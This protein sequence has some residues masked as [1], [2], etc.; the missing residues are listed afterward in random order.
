MRAALALPLHRIG[1]AA[2]LRLIVWALIAVTKSSPIPPRWLL[3]TVP[4]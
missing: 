3:D 4:K 2:R 1:H